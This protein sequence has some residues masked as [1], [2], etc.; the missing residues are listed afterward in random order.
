MVGATEGF[1]RLM[2]QKADEQESLRCENFVEMLDPWTSG[3]EGRKWS[4]KESD[5]LRTET[6]QEHV[7]HRGRVIRHACWQLGVALMYCDR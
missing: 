2:P 4:K 1:S 5:E 3:W 7:L 6:L